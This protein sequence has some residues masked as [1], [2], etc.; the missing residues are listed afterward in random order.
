M[1]IAEFFRFWA[2]EEGPCVTVEAISELLAAVAEKELCITYHYF[3]SLKAD[4]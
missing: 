3:I 2:L 1:E 4:S